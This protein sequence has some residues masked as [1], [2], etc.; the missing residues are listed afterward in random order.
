MRLRS[1]SKA[2]KNTPKSTL[3]V[4]EK[5][6]FLSAVAL[7]VLFSIWSCQDTFKAVSVGRTVGTH[8]HYHWK[9]EKYFLKVKYLYLS[10]FS[11]NMIY[12]I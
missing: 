12:S 3:P 7:P 2:E 5:T 1:L 10:I 4:Y 9:N 11:I 8:P 6:D